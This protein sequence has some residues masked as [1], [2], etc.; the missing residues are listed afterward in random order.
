MELQKKEETTNDIGCHEQASLPARYHCWFVS[1]TTLTN[2]DSDGNLYV[3]QQTAAGDV[4]QNILTW[5]NGKKVFFFP[6]PRLFHHP[7]EL[8]GHVKTNPSYIAVNASMSTS[9]N[10]T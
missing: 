7:A 3:L 6:T 1:T 8:H 9:L 2:E 5:K 4:F 10:R